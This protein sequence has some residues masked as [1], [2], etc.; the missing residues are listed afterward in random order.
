MVR[1][2]LCSLLAALL[3]TVSD[4]SA[5]EAASLAEREGKWSF[6][7]SEPGAELKSVSKEKQ[8]KIKGSLQ[9]ISRLVTSTPAMSPLKGFEARFWGSLTAKDRY[10]SCSGKKCP[11]SRPAA[12]LAIMLARYEE[13]NGKVRAAF[14]TPST[15]DISINN[16]GHLFAHLPVLYKDSEGYLLPEP[17]LDGERAGMTT[18]QN[19]GHAV[20]VITGSDKPLW[21]PVS[22]ERYLKAAIAAVAKDT[23]Q[24]QTP[25]KK[26]KKKQLT[27]VSI[28]SGK[29]ILVEESRTWID[30]AE[31]K[32]WVESSRSLAYDLKEP[33]EVLQGRLKSL[34]SELAAMTPEQR[35]LQARVEI[36]ATD[37]GETPAL[38]PSDSSAGVAVVTPDFRYFN[39]KLPADAIQL[40]VVQW[41]FDG[42]M[43]YDPDKPGITESVNN[44]KLLEIYRTMDWQ[45]L[46]GMVTR[47]AP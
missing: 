17:K 8:K 11:P 15:M 46:R 35:S 33:L 26:V 18:Y 10:D 23:G 22:R 27:E 21:Q 45:K 29:P 47:T 41:K 20:A 30:P 37:G 12:V 39:P 19:N 1:I 16:M 36:V 14:N 24:T 28:I 32:K 4:V 5:E 7:I 3:F 43:L 9:G 34:E 6:S 31:E 38:L 44:R 2:L 25:A 40:V 13:S 42:N